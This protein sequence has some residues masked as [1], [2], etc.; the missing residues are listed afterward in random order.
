MLIT[1]LGFHRGYPMFRVSID[2]YDAIRVTVGVPQQRPGSGDCGVFV[3]KII[4]YLCSG[5]PFNF[6]PHDGLTLRQ[7]IDVSMLKDQ[8]V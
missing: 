6:G 7:K 8:I 3:L 2:P 1:S 5:S 4:E